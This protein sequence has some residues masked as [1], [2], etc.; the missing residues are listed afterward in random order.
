ME[1]WYILID[2]QA[3]GPVTKYTLLSYNPASDSQVWREGMP[4]WQ[5]LYT[6][7][8]LYSMLNDRSGYGGNQLQPYPYGQYLPYS[9][10]STSGKSRAVAGLLAIFF[11]VFGAQYF[12]LGK[13]TAG[14]M[15]LI[16]MFLFNVIFGTLSLLTLGIGLIIYLPILMLLNILFL[17]QGIIMFASDKHKFD[18][19]YVYSSLTFPLF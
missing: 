12:Y 2:G 16:G 6:V 4:Q 3:V 1:E 10:Q 13:T 5:P 18:S 15:M 7:Y 8:E 17:I 14:F 19:K 9:Y 11:W